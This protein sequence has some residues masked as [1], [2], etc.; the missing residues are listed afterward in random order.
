M[1]GAE[2]RLKIL[3]Y[4]YVLCLRLCHS[5]RQR[6]RS[7]GDIYGIHYSIM[8]GTYLLAF[9]ARGAMAF[10][11]QFAAVLVRLAPHDSRVWATFRHI[12][13]KARAGFLLAASMRL[14]LKHADDSLD[15]FIYSV[16]QYAFVD[17]TNC[18]S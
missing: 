12:H 15:V 8:V 4:A 11:P 7:T 5:L 6:L 14:G 1:L 18:G 16:F 9:L 10:A 17:S 13:A 3:A 2:T